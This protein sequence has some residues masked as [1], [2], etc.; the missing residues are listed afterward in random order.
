MTSWDTSI[1]CSKLRGHDL[2]TNLSLCKQ[3]IPC[4]KPFLRIFITYSAVEVLGKRED[5]NV[6][7]C[8][9]E[10]KSEV[11]RFR[12]STIYQWIYRLE[13]WTICT[14]MRNNGITLDLEW[15]TYLQGTC[16]RMQ[17]FWWVTRSGFELALRLLYTVTGIGMQYLFSRKSQ[18]ANWNDNKC[19]R[20]LSVWEGE[21]SNNGKFLV[22]MCIHPVNHLH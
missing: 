1:K 19:F 12:T 15:R 16:I 4:V 3:N 2:S 7:L 6:N 8:C 10:R 18:R 22:W 11:V 21:G 20:T 5:I 17:E 14:V 9:W 13:I